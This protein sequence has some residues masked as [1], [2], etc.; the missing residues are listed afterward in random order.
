MAT[1]L[2]VS[3][4]IVTVPSPY[5]NLIIWWRVDGTPPS[6]WNHGLPSSKEKVAGIS[7]TIN[8]TSSSM[9]PT[10]TMVEKTP[11]TPRLLSSYALI[12]MP[13]GVKPSSCSPSLGRIFN[14]HTLMED[15][16]ST[17]TH[18]VFFPFTSALMNRARL[19]PLPSIGSSSSVKI[20]ACLSC[21]CT[22]PMTSVGSASAGTIILP[23]ASTMAFLCS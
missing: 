22:D 3:A 11:S 5:G 13:E 23:S 8:S 21:F 18:E 2:P 12:V 7:S 10:L 20:R 14:G 15:P 4:P 16:S 17:I 6:L 9:G 1:A 19:W